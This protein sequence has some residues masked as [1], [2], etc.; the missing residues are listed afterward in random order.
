MSVDLEQFRALVAFATHGHFTHAAEAI[1]ASQSAF[2]RRIQALE[3]DLGQTLIDRS[4]TPPTLTECGKVVLATALTVLRCAD[5]L[6]LELDDLVSS[7][8][9]HT[10]VGFTA[11]ALGGIT[12]KVLRSYREIDP[13]LRMTEIRNDEIMAR[14]EDDSLDLVLGCP[15]NGTAASHVSII[16]SE[17]EAVMVASNHRLAGA[18]R[19]AASDYADE[20]FVVLS[21]MIDADLGHLAG[22]LQ[23]S[24]CVETFAEATQ[25]VAIGAGIHVVPASYALR[26][27]H[28]EIRYIPAI[29]LPHSPIG[30]TLPPK[31]TLKARQFQRLALKI[32]AETPF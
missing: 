15:P 25:L 31:P 11:H 16:G 3:T 8:V 18:T 5:N 19:L 2:T 32:A 14:L 7:E 1:H 4:E 29:D 23:I 27:Q 9:A 6:V 13:N 12:T 17:P 30:L 26:H 21:W 10:R 28:H 24:A 20:P 22:L